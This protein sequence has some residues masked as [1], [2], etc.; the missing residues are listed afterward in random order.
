M[1]TVYT[2]CPTDYFGSNCYLIGSSDSWAVID[3]SISYSRACAKYPEIEGKIK[4]ILLTHGHFDHICEID[5]WTDA[6]KDVMIGSEDGK[7]LSDSS[8]NCYL[9]FLGIDGGYHGEYTS[10]T[11][12]DII[13]LGEEEISVVTT[14][15]HTPGSVCYKASDAVFTGD[16]LFSNGGYG[17]CDLPGGD[18][19]ALWD[20]LF[21]LFSQNML[22]KFYPGHGFPDSFENSIKPC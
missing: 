11:D 13:K 14:P 15:G 17:R 4:Y 6:C 9:G 10:L 8:L 12:G 3:P 16:T 22:G 5:S 18:I 7:M 20:S 19:D 21:K 1:L 2:I